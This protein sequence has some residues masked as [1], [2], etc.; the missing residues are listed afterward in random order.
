VLTRARGGLAGLL[1]LP[2]DPIVE[3]LLYS[4]DVARGTGNGTPARRPRTDL[5]ET[6]ELVAP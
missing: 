2:R 1:F 6:K 4:D 3:G 5:D